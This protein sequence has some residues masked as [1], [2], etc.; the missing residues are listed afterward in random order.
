MSQWIMW[1]PQSV[2]SNTPLHILR[3]PFPHIGRYIV[4]QLPPPG[5]ALALPFL[6]SR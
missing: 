4:E 1:V 3:Q 6:N 2:G 5:L